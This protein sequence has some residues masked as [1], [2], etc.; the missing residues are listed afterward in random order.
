MDHL[1]IEASL[2]KVDRK[3]TEQLSN[4]EKRRVIKEFKLVYAGMVANM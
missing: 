2:R 3:F 1:D 4:E